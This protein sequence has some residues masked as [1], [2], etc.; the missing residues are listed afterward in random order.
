MTGILFL[1]CVW[2]GF[3]G[4]SALLFAP[5]FSGQAQEGDARTSP[6]ATAV[7]IA[8]PAIVFIQGPKP[9]G[10]DQ[11]DCSAFTLGIIVDPKGIVVTNYSAI[12]DMKKCEVVLRD[13]RKFLPKA[14]ASDP[15][16]GLTLIKIKDAKPLPFAAVED[17]KKVKVGDRVIALSAP[18]TTLVDDPVTVV[19]GLIGGK[20]RGTKNGDSLF[21]V[22]TAT[23]PGCS[24]GPLLNKEGKFVGLLLSRDLSPRRNAAIPS[25]RVKERMAE[26]SKEK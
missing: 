2:A 22:D 1:P 6:L 9:K 5:L 20:T 8:K 4:T 17:S 3:I 18:W 14:V 15:A 12:K 7:K 19:A 23:G 11:A 13:G 25:N 10:T 24:P 26:W 21:L 16:L